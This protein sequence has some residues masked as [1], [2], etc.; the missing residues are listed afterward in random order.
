VVHKIQAGYKI[1]P[2]S[3]W[4]KT[5]E[6]V[7]VEIDPTI[8]MKTPPKNGESKR[9]PL[10]SRKIISRIIPNPAAAFQKSAQD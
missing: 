9:R 8:D 6:P 4:G 2:L 3:Q 5:L 1:T 7:E 10:E